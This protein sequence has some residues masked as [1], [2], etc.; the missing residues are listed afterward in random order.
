[1]GKVITVP[2]VGTWGYTSG[3][4]GK[5]MKG[6]LISKNP[7]P[8]AKKAMQN[9]KTLAAANG[10]KMSDCIKTTVFLTDMEHFAAVNEQYAKFFKGDAPGRSCVAVHQLPKGALFEVEAVFFKV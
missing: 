9:L 7:G 10:F 2:G 8:Q 5:N 6:E 1:M 4:I 3:S